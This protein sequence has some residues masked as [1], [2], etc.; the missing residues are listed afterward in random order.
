MNNSDFLPPS[1]LG[2]MSQQKSRSKNEKEKK[3]Q[4]RCRAWRASSKMNLSQFI[5]CLR[6]MSPNSRPKANQPNP[7]VS[8][9]LFLIFTQTY[10]HPEF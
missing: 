6:R 10:R 8:M 1:L 3:K 9:P 5:L 2:E 4:K 7:L